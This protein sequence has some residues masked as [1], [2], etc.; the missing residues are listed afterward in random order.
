[1]SD[2]HEFNLTVPE[3]VD[4]VFDWHKRPGAVHRLIPPWQPVH[5]AQEARPLRD[6]TAILQFPAGRQW[7]A[8]HL[9]DEYVEGSKFAD[10][11]ES[12]PFI[13]PI[14]W[15]HEHRFEPV[16]D[17]TAVIDRVTTSVPGPML[18][19]MFRYRHRQL[20]DDLTAHRWAADKPRLTVAITGA[21]G[22]V[23][24]AL[25]PYLTTGG[26]TVI[27]LVRH[28]PTGDNERR[29]NPDAPDPAMLDGVDAVIHLA[30][31][32]IAGRFTD[33]HK[34]AVR[35]S[36][37]EPTRKLA[38][39]V[40]AA[41]VPVFVSASAIGIYGADRGGETLSDVAAPGDGFL[42]DVVRDWEASALEAESSD[43]RVVLVRTGIVQSPR[44]G[45]LQLQRPLFA[46][47]FGGRLGSGDQWTSWIEIDDL[48][49][50]YHRAL[51]DPAL[52]GPVNAVA[53]RPVRQREYASVLAHV[54]HRPAL[55]PTPLAATRL[56]LGREGEREVAGASQRVLP[57]ALTSLG[58]RFRFPD[59]EPALR[60]LLGKS[61]DPA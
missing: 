12:R 14:N 47:G 57:S 51:F 38:R 58:H 45:A 61:T 5:A 16:A 2:V 48:L 19:S 24:S 31:E 52:H 6:G 53:P 11:L 10:R 50:I 3:P 18:R 43:T 56:L 46:A 21:S 8:Q 30:G 59:L 25:A 4:V 17:G 7:V 41:G 27:R 40:A 26:H 60:H 9:A 23:G 49:D 34:R 28:E 37:I 29:W 44:G 15:H 20:A 22:L 35:D 36:R 54:L 42:A 55:V 32:S 33:A 13:V 39:A 1:M